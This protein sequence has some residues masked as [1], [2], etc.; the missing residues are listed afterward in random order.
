M[1]AWPW[2]A[3]P[4][5]AKAAA[6]AGESCWAMIGCPGRG[7]VASVTVRLLDATPRPWLP[8]GR[9]A[10]STSPTPALNAADTAQ[11]FT[12]AVRGEL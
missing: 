12:D 10:G 9:L 6:T 4:G 7:K 8:V 1:A 2:A 5:R 11:L 3:A